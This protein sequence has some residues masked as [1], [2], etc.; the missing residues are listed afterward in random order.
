[1]YLARSWAWCQD[2]VFCPAAEFGENDFIALHGQDLSHE[3]WATPEPKDCGYPLCWS[4]PIC[5]FV[6]SISCRFG[7]YPLHF[8]PVLCLVLSLR[9]ICEKETAV[10]DP[11]KVL[12]LPFRRLY[13]KLANRL[14]LETLPPRCFLLILPL[15]LRKAPSFGKRTETPLFKY[16]LFFAR[17]GVQEL[18]KVFV[19][20]KD[21]VCEMTFKW[22]LY[23]TRFELRD[24]FSVQLDPCRIPAFDLHPSANVLA[25]VRCVVQ[26]STSRFWEHTILGKQNFSICANGRQ[27]LFGR[28]SPKNLWSNRFGRW[29]R[30]WALT[31][32][33]AL[34]EPS[35]FSTS[36]MSAF[37]S[38]R[39][40]IVK[41]LLFWEHSLPV[42]FL[43]FCLF[44]VWGCLLEWCTT[45]WC[46]V[47]A[48][49]GFADRLE[50]PHTIR[51]AEPSVQGT[52]RAF[53]TQ[54]SLNTSLIIESCTLSIFPQQH[55]RIEFGVSSLANK[56][57]LASKNLQNKHLITVGTGFGNTRAPKTHHTMRNSRRLARY[58]AHGFFLAPRRH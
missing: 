6:H 48:S 51:F 10:Q 30:P 12:Q 53:T 38:F 33:P 11:S 8:A 4:F 52:K 23:L 41:R 58:K 25:N 40:N 13:H 28:A 42:F 19:C 50:M 22:V 3:D 45:A 27:A 36:K 14:T 43:L 16:N 24:Y 55:N 18:A 54:G 35:S 1:M 29:A 5:V 20:R 49:D 34:E 21:V 56:L 47:G 44:S 46:F 17:V 37:A 31:V 2:C 26:N 39:N 57:H 15:F 7:N 32:F 9:F